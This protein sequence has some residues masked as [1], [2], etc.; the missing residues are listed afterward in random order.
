M[1]NDT[2]VHLV[3]HGQVDNPTGVLY[4]RLPGF[5]L[6]ELGRRMAI[7]LAE[8]FADASV[9]HLRCSPLERARETIAPLAGMRPQLDI[10]ID[11]RVIE[12][13]N[14]FEGKRFGTDNA[15][16][17]DPKM[18]WHVRNPFRPSWG[19]PYVRIAARMAEAVADAAHDAGQGGQAV[20]LSHQ[21][22]IWM[23]RSHYE[24]RRLAHDP[25]RRECTLAS[26]TTLTL[27]RRALS[28]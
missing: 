10:T 23:A 19:E 1:N 24:G 11:E 22:P 8:Y 26:V 20:I 25:R 7:R 16:L 15:A 18:L 12:A 5:H 14:A 17:R 28:R 4:G 6:S 27:R 21:L 9:T 3:R 2:L 13:E